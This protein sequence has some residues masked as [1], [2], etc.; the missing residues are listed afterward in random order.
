M[1]VYLTI[2]LPGAELP[3]V[4]SSGLLNDPFPFSSILDTG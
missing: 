2:L 4:E 3:L 1:Y